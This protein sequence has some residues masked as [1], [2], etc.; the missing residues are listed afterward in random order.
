MYSLSSAQQLIASVDPY[1]AAGQAARAL[2]RRERR[3]GTAARLWARLTG[4]PAH[5]LNLADVIADAPPRAQHAGGIRGVPI[6]AIGG[7]EGR[8]GDFDA[9]FHPRGGQTAE[10]WQRVAAAMIGGRPLPAV[11]LIQVGATYFVRDGHH[12][13]SVARALGQTSIDAVVT[14][15]DAPPDGGDDP[16]RNHRQL[17]AAA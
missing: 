4:R 2:Y 8:D 17:F 3:A 16:H 15:W 13:V 12:R 11:E 9:A 14:V 10:R 1:G 6:A 5:L 7:S